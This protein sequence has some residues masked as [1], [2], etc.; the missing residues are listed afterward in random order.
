M[1][2]E[3]KNRSFR[4]SEE[5]TE[6]FRQ[7]CTGFDNQNTALNALITAYEIQ[8]AQAI[9]T[10]RQ[11]DISDYDTHL[12]ALQRAFLHSL[13]LNEN[14]E[15]RIRQEFQRQLESK[16]SIILDF[17]EHVRQAEQAEQTARN[18]LLIT[19][20]NL[21]DLTEQ[22]TSQIDNL[23]TELT[24]KQNTFELAREQIAEKN[25]KLEEL[26]K[27]LV[28][29]QKDAESIPELNAKINALTQKQATTEQEN[30]QLKAE[31]E[32]QKKDFEMKLT[33]SEKQAELEKQQAILAE[34]QKE[35]QNTKAHADELKRLYDE[36][37]ELR[38]ELSRSEPETK[39]EENQ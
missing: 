37:N 29:A 8:Q 12:Q 32:K 3:L 7:L 16:N 24:N 27:Q 17:Q 28:Q 20:K 19:E 11:T 5:T 35:A 22:T 4:I 9:I 15:S 25:T 33:M 21:S 2:N 1:A 38:K 39:K 23:Q 10:E 34:Q 18:Q 36:I 26:R 6:K 14:A 31:I 30:K 13:E